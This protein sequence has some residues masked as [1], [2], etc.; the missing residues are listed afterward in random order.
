MGEW[1][2]WNGRVYLS[3]DRMVTPPTTPMRWPPTHLPHMHP[4]DWNEIQTTIPMTTGPPYPQSVSVLSDI[5]WLRCGNATQH[6]MQTSSTCKINEGHEKFFFNS[7]FSFHQIWNPYTKGGDISMH[8][9]FSGSQKIDLNVGNMPLVPGNV[10]FFS[11]ESKYHCNFFFP[12]KVLYKRFH[13]PANHCQ[14]GR[15]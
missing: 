1:F 13:W 14:R 5:Q 7:S 2:N 3:G 12:C 15:R 10:F 9:E 11:S 6:H 4:L 8:P